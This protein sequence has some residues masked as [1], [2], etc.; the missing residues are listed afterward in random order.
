L[1][2]FVP[3]FNHFVE[4]T[5]AGFG[6]TA[7]IIGARMVGR[8]K[9][10]APAIVSPLQDDPLL[11]NDELHNNDFDFDGDPE[12]RKCPFAAHIR[13]AYPRNDVT[14]AGLGKPTDFDRREASEAD[15]E[16][17]RIMRRGIPFGDEVTDNEQRNETTAN[18]R[19]LMFV[20]YQTSIVEQF[21]FLTH[22]W[23][24][25]PA[26][27]PAGSNPGF[28][29]LLGQDPAHAPR[30][31]KGLDVIYPKGPLGGTTTLPIDFIRPTGGGYFFV[32]SISTIKNHIA[33]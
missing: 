4:T 13:K 32:P 17:H 30:P 26:F 10:G 33:A 5:A 9:S 7:D 2:Q 6:T 27:A 28:D 14:P 21:E 18:E 31:V 3:E 22:N 25:N 19:G 29:P 1:N 8:W 16:T 15:T 11:G 20:C 23:V 24:N 12:G